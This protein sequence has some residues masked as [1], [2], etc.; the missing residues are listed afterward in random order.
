MKNNC[1]YFLF[2]AFSRKNESLMIKTE[3]EN[4]EIMRICP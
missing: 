3:E 1:D 4:P 2:Y